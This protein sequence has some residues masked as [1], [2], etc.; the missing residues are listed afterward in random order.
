M[1]AFH[2]VTGWTSR[3]MS[4]PRAGWLRTPRMRWLARISMAS[5]VL[6]LPGAPE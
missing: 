1:I 4:T 3:E 5:V 2:A 6:P